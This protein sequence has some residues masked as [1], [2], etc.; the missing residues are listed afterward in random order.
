MPSTIMPMA[1]PRIQVVTEFGMILIEADIAPRF[2]GIRIIHGP[3]SSAGVRGWRF[4]SPEI[5]REFITKRTHS[6]VCEGARLRF[7][8]KCC[9]FVGFVVAT[10]Q[11][12]TCGIK[13]C[14]VK[15][16]RRL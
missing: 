6:S 16:E 5:H 7:G 14:N 9:Y 13:F 11:K 8:A 1:K 15:I 3:N 4:V 10:T 2:D 12:P